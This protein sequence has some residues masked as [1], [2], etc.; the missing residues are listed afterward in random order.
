MGVSSI[1]AR[2]DEV[3]SLED[4]L[5]S[6]FSE[7]K[8][9]EE[10]IKVEKVD[11]LDSKKEDY[12]PSYGVVINAKEDRKTFISKPIK[13]TKKVVEKSL[14]VKEVKVSKEK[15]LDKVT[16]KKILPTP[17]SNIGDDFDVAW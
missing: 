7:L 13:A 9:G 17:T 11:V 2:K 10:N 4:A 15:S 6:G 1:M 5:E 3:P 16:E 14:E 12:D 8:A